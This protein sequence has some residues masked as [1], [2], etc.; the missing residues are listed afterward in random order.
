MLDNV[1]SLV[2]GE[3]MGQCGFDIFLAVCGQL[4]NE[5]KNVV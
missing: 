1:V 5:A 3:G 4:V 2:P